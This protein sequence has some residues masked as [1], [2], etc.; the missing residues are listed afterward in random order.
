MGIRLRGGWTFTGSIDS[1]PFSVGTSFT[2]PA[3]VGLYL[4]SLSGPQVGLVK[5]RFLNIVPEPSSLALLVGGLVMLTAP[6]W[7]A[8]LTRCP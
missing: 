4:N 7:P 6:L 2:S 8:W 5:N 1:V 3:A